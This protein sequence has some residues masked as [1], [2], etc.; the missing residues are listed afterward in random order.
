MTECIDVTIKDGLAVILLSRR[1]VG[2]WLDAAQRGDILA[3]LRSL[4]PK[5]RDPK[6]RGVLIRSEDR[7]LAAH[8]DAGPDLPSQDDAK[9]PTLAELCHAVATCPVPVVV[10]MD[11]PVSGA[12]AELALAAHARIATSDTRITFSAGR[13]G[14]ISGAGSTQRLPRLIGAE[15]ALRLL[16]VG[17]PVAAAE[18]LM[19]GLVDKVVAEHAPADNLAL[20]TAWALSEAAAVSRSSPLA[21]SRG[22]LRAVSEIRAGVA[23]GSLAA[24]LA[25]CVEAA[26]LLPLDQGLAFEAAAA[27]ERD[28]LPEV[29]AL[30]HLFRA[31]RAVSETPQALQAVKVAPVARPALVGAAA[32]V[33]GLVLMALS[34][35]L[36][37]TV[38]D[39]DR[40]RLVPML[41]TIASRQEA[42]VQAGNLSAA[43]RDA[44]W[45]RL[46]PVA[47]AATLEQADLVIVAPDTAIPTVRPA[48]PLLVM[49]RAELPKGALRLVLSGRVAELGL[50]PACPAQ[51]AAQALAF[52]RSLGM[53]VVLTGVQSPLGISGRLAGAGGAAMR[54]L[55]E[56]G[57]SAEAI[58]S[59]LKEFGLTATNLP[60][61]E[62]ALAPRR[63]APDEILNRWLG[64]LA[65]EGARLLASGLAL[66]PADIDLVAVQ[67]LGLPPDCGGPMHA[68][69]QR[70]LM[71]LRRDLTLWGDEADVW[72]PVPALDALVSIG[73]GFA[74]SLSRG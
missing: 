31:E 52:L 56:S 61:P 44:D 26:L 21:D 40:G 58:Q 33:S 8:R 55:L 67:G 2:A 13:L 23:Q 42:A 35:G 47:D 37:V 12:A 4:D 53:T 30:S 66:S 72:K 27:L 22:F 49:G 71:I 24:T 68:A 6:V 64:A 17:K 10:F 51:P 25:E 38:Q 5:V 16:L 36:P 74:D 20:A 32:S 59:A 29:A 69:D 39:Q 73:R 7:M 57:V 50:P 1:P 62:A 15:H 65:N 60:T 54:S 46:T 34:R 63:M 3:M 70:G 11:G 48:V 28:A 9:D 18:A 45:A 14:R 43:Q 41:E 19:L